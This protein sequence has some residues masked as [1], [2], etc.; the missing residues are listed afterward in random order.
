MDGLP[1]APPP[2]LP[3]GVSSSSSSNTND[4]GTGP[5]PPRSPPPPA[6]DTTSSTSS[7]SIAPRDTLVP[8]ILHHDSF[9]PSSTSTSSFPPPPPSTQ[10]PHHQPPSLTPSSSSRPTSPRRRTNSDDGSRSQGPSSATSQTLE[11]GGEDDPSMSSARGLDR[12]TAVRRGLACPLCPPSTLLHHPYTLPCG[13]TL[14]DA[15]SLST[16]SSSSSST[17]HRSNCP[18]EGC[19]WTPDELKRVEISPDVVL[20]KVLGLV[21]ARGGGEEGGGGLDWEDSEMEREDEGEGSKGGGTTTEDSSDDEGVDAEGEIEGGNP[22]RKASKRQR[23]S[24]AAPSTRPKPHHTLS[25]SDL[26][27]QLASS[28]SST[29]N[30][31]RLRS[32]NSACSS[33]SSS[34]H[35][36]NNGGSASSSSSP[37][38]GGGSSRPSSSRGAGSSSTRKISGEERR[39]SPA[40][41]GGGRK[42]RGGAEKEMT[43]L[44]DCDVCRNMLFE[45]VTTGCGHTFCR[46]C[47]ARSLDHSPKCPL[48]RSDL[49]VTTGRGMAVNR[50][51]QNILTTAFP[52]EYADRKLGVE[53]GERDARM[54]IP[55][56][57]CTLAFPF[58]P[59]ILHVFEPRYRLMLRRC[60]ESNSPRFGMVLPPRESSIGSGAVEYGTM[61]E[62]RSVQMLN[63]G[64]SMIETVGSWRFKVLEKGTLDGYTVGR[65]ERLDDISPEDEAEMERVAVARG[66]ARAAEPGASS[67]RPTPSDPPAPQPSSPN[68]SSSSSTT[69]P[70]I[71]PTSPDIPVSDALPSPNNPLIRSTPSPPQ[72]AR[73]PALQRTP[74]QPG[75]H[76]NPAD[77]STA[78]LMAICQ[79][80]IDHLRS[81]SAPWLLQ[82]LNNTYGPMP[83]DPSVCGYWM[84]SVIPIDE[85]EKAKLL[86]IRS[87]RLRLALIVHWVEQ[88]RSSWWFSS[89]CVCS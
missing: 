39:R 26:P 48:C 28:S 64:R 8:L 50:V 70:R 84:A 35:P 36:S 47:I 73:P 19:T 82:R 42:G 10:P 27:A 81:G 72:S 34:P 13:H 18:I 51:L 83:S 40:V 45:P 6:C 38:R 37:R 44:M 21:V 57:V 69:P 86:P 33:R 4:I 43:G 58:M 3:L 52:S 46:R 29:S 67:S 15:H 30:R 78:E 23:R 63:D 60:I 55:I 14:C 49:P 87:P 59:T 12:W 2:P 25:A 76:R 54:D 22:S 89:G 17:S 1:P 88:L 74:T 11:T 77:L 79:E 41:E 65:V 53:Q 61:L 24:P 68:S 5:T 32:S 66:Q 7:S 20:G 31:H 75:I 16:S 56:F 9:S 71:P 80:F 62:I 85:Y